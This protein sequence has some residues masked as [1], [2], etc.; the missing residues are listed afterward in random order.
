M[1]LHG[2]SS[3]QEGASLFVRFNCDQSYGNATSCG[4]IG[5]Q[6]FN[7]I[8]GVNVQVFPLAN[9]C[10]ACPPTCGN[11]CGPNHNEPC[12]GVNSFLQETDGSGTYWTGISGNWDQ[13]L[14]DAL[15]WRRSHRYCGDGLDIEV[16]SKPQTLVTCFSRGSCFSTLL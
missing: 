5:E 1:D 7:Q 11:V 14:I 6:F 12:C 4:G 8:F 16:Y 3:P 10:M 13:S 9:V 15:N 2:F